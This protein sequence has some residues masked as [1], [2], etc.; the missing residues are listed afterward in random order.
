MLLPGSRYQGLSTL[1]Y[2]APSGQGIAYLAPRTV[3]P[4]D[5]AQ[6]A[7][8]VPVAIVNRLDL[9][10]ASEIGDPLLFWQIADVNPV[11]DPFALVERVGEPV[12]IPTVGGKTL[13]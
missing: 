1:L 13:R 5:P 11:L 3:P 6:V 9:I 10:A 8:L 7:A 12:A 4:I 2:P